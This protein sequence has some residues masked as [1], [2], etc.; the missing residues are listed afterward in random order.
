[1]SWQLLRLARRCWFCPTVLEAGDLARLGEHT[2]GVWCVACALRQLGETPPAEFLAPATPPPAIEAPP[3]QDT[4][5]DLTPEGA[6][7]KHADARLA[8]DEL[9]SRIAEQAAAAGPA[10]EGGDQA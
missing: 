3:E 2:P 9:R 4:L 1:M 10:P 8:L 5:F 7:L 6:K